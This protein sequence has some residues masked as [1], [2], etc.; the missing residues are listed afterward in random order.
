MKHSFSIL[1]LV[2]V[3][4]FLG[5]FLGS[6]VNIALPQIEKDFLLNS[7]QLSWIVTAFLLS[8]AMFLLPVG[9][10]GD[11]VG[12]K[13]IFKIGLVIFSIASMLCALSFSGTQLII[14]RFFQ[15][16]GAAFVSTTGP[17]ILVSEFPP[18]KRGRVLGISVSAVYLGLALGPILGGVIAF[19]FGWKTLFY[20]SAA[21]GTVILFPA[22]SILQKNTKDFKTVNYNKQTFRNVILFLLGLPLLIYSTT[23]FPKVH[24]W[25]LFLTGLTLLSFYIFL[26]KKSEFPAFEVKLFF[27]NR[28][29][30][31]SNLAALI[32]Y[33]ATFAIIFMLSLYLQKVK[34]LSP[35]EAG[36]ILVFQPVIMAIFSPITG[37]LSDK[38]Q[39]RYLASLGMLFC[40]IGLL[41][42]SFLTETSSIFFIIALLVIVGFGIA[43]FS[44][45][46]MNTIMSSVSKQYYG[47]ASGTAATMRVL[48]QIF[49]MSIVAIFFV[50]FFGKTAVNQIENEIFLRA[51]KFIFL[52]LSFICIIGMILSFY[53]G[54]LER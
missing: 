17:A 9:K 10:L 43:L 45:P 40:S 46:N 49:S 41:G 23:Q 35:R 22:F 18:Q 19:Y 14:F 31:F 11:I 34:H 37:R 21:I 33:S 20:L 32:N 39:P 42:F 24:G 12:I 38:I 3:S 36:M 51:E 4:S 50:V 28:I 8:T 6:A 1:L 54:K 5:S 29:Y 47:Q 25:I 2:A 13:V 7:L 26:E 53:R 16:I 44:S 30:L 52:I 27:K 15:G 48:G